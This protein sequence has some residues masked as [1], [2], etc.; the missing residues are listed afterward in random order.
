MTKA[1]PKNKKRHQ[2]GKN[3]ATNNK[4][5]QFERKNTK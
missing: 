5:K 4:M 3:L 1:T 2:K